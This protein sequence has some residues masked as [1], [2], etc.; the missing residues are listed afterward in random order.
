MKNDIIYKLLKLF[1][2]VLGLLPRRAAT[3]C[4]DSLGLLWFKIDKRHRTIALE[5]IS[6][7]YRTEFSP[8]QVLLLGKKV[9]QNTIHII[10][11]IAWAFRK[12]QEE[13]LTY[14]TIKG[15]GNLKNALKKGRGVLL[16]SGHIGNFELLVAAFG[17]DPDFKM[18]G[19]YRKLD[20]QPIERLMLE[21]RQR[22][23]T[24]MIPLQ[25]AAKKIDAILRNK[26]AVG[27]LL[28]QNADWYNGVF[29]DFFGRPAC[30][31]KGM[32]ILAMRTKALVV[33]MCIAKTGDTFV[34]EFLPEIPLESTGDMIKDIETN[35]QNY[36][37]AIEAMVRKYPDQYFW[38]HNRWKTKPYDLIPTK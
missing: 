5:N 7:A 6:K 20:F 13:L 27:T 4:S 26:D 3:F 17:H 36:T 28:D 25:G 12:S 30:T 2:I 16:L 8:V 35:T 9:F 33:P 23:G 32:A 22:F 14:Y 34:V 24:T 10:F 19:A 21:E 31:N 18:Y 37:A 1:I 29:V 15:Y 38:V 11:D